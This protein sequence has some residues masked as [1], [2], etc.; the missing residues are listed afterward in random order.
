M[1]QKY[2]NI[3]K[4]IAAIS[5]YFRESLQELHKVT[6]PTK[7]QAI[8]LTVIVLIFCF[9]SAGFLMLVDLGFGEIYSQLIS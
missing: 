6:W 3:K 5:N 1:L 7:N 4:M 9:L 2:L 8:R